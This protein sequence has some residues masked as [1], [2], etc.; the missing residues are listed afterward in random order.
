MIIEKSL[1]ISSIALFLRTRLNSSSEG[2]RS[3]IDLSKSS[4]YDESKSETKKLIST[5][6]KFKC[7]NY[8]FRPKVINNQSKMGYYYNL[9]KTLYTLEMGDLL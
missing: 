9:K 6:L 2:I 7:S 4:V 1:Q 5:S 8:I 3:L